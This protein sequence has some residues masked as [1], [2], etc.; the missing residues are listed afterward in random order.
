V[1]GIDGSEPYGIVAAA[2]GRVRIVVDGF[3]GPERNNEVWLEHPNALRRL[4]CPSGGRC[5][6]PSDNPVA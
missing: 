6:L 2:T 5:G 3:T 1:R 4:C